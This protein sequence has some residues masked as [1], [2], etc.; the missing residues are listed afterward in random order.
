M[1]AKIQAQDEIQEQ[2]DQQQQQ[3]Q[4]QQQEPDR[5]WRERWRASHNL[6]YSLPD[7]VVRMIVKDYLTREE[8]W[9]L[10]RLNAVPGWKDVTKTL[11]EGEEDQVPDG[12]SI[13]VEEQR[14]FADELPQRHDDYT[15]LVVLG[16]KSLR[17]QRFLKEKF[18][19]LAFNFLAREVSPEMNEL[20]GPSKE[21][22]LVYEKCHLS[23]GHQA[24]LFPYLAYKE[25]RRRIVFANCVVKLDFAMKFL[26][27]EALNGHREDTHGNL[28]LEIWDCVDARG[29]PADLVG[30]LKCVWTSKC[31]W[32]VWLHVYVAVEGVDNGA[33]KKFKGRPL[34]LDAYRSRAR[35]LTFE[36][37][38]TGTKRVRACLHVVEGDYIPVQDPNTFAGVLKAV[39]EDP[40]AEAA[41]AEEEAWD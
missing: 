32:F 38:G 27:K 6:L 5:V 3:Q 17:G 19:V 1:A 10:R 14:R 16:F 23:C 11:R 28:A 33:R 40:E 18:P 41:A 13:E 39:P 35:G 8:M 30:L 21:R 37:M 36:P 12:T 7:D 25:L 4:K 24:Q 31:L 15:K 29:R 26:L 34:E 2:Q 22:T 9:T 20:F